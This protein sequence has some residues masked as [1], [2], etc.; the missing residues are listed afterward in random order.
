MKQDTSTKILFALVFIVVPSLYIFCRVVPYLLFYALPFAS[1]SV[2]FASLWVAG[3]SLGDDDYSWLGVIIPLS[4]VGVFLLVGFPKPP[5]ILKGGALAIDG[6]YFFDWFNHTKAW[7]DYALWHVIPEGLAFL[8]PTVPPNEHYDL[9]T[10]RWLFWISLGI[11][12]PLVFMFLSA[13]KARAVKRTIEAKYQAIHEENLAQ[14]DN[15]KD[16]NSDRI[17]KMESQ[18]Q[19]IQ[20]ERDHYRDE[21]AKL[22]TLLAFQK[23]ADGAANDPDGNGKKGVLDSE[24]L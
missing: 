10:I 23:K 9:N 18:M 3:A 2:L 20:Q 4:A 19:G 6:V 8:A 16:E 15:A 5:L 1:F 21:H 22:K 17:R 14:L 12:A 7:F 11:G 13:D 24:D